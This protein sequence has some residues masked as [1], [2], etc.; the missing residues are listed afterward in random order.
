VKIVIADD[1]E[2]ILDTLREMLNPFSRAEI[3]AT[4]KNGNDA[5]EA[6]RTLKPDL[7]IVD[8]Q[9]PGLTGLQVVAETRKENKTTPFI[10]LTFYSSGYYRQQAILAGADYF[11]SKTDDFQ[12][13]AE[14]VGEMLKKEEKNKNT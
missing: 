3:V 8:I 11:F 13:I 6:I 9:M 14:V 7:A 5:L 1:S 2:M 10:I 12:K 4:C